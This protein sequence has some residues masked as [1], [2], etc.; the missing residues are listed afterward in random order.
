MKERRADASPDST[1]GEA[2]DLV[3]RLRASLEQ[4]RRRPRYEIVQ[5]ALRR[6][7]QTGDLPTNAVLPTELDLAE[8]LGISRQTIRHALN[9]LTRAGLLTRRRGIGTFVGSN[10]IVH[11]LGQLSSFV[12][13]LALEGEPPQ[14]RLLGVRFTVDTVASPLL[15]GQ[16]D[17]ILFEMSRLF[18]V[19]GEPFALERIYLPREIGAALPVDGLSA[20]VVD[21]MIREH[22][23]IDV[24]RGTEVVELIRVGRE[25]AALMETARD[26]PAFL[27]TRTASSG[28]RPIE[29]RRSIVRGDRAR[30]RIELS[31]AQ[32][33]SLNR[34]P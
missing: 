32:L 8:A 4:D 14:S 17:G 18:A 11:P 26:E 29:L 6:A 7:I 1:G 31:G 3:A 9:E 13:T 19:E 25:E 34:A 10:S 30:F 27:I 5:E 24:D 16:A 22:A 28:D 15:T 33:E 2:F 21:D 23:G 20:A 12:R